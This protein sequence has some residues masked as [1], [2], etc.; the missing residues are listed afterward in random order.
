MHKGC[1]WAMNVG[2]MA[3]SLQQV[4]LLLVCSLSPM[5][6]GSFSTSMATRHS[7]LAPPP[8]VSSGCALRLRGGKIQESDGLVGD[9]IPNVTE[10]VTEDY[11]AWSF[12]V[13]INTSYFEGEKDWSKPSF[14]DL[15]IEYFEDKYNVKQEDI[16]EYFKNRSLEVINKARKSDDE[17]PIELDPPTF[18]TCHFKN[19]TYRFCTT[20]MDR[21]SIGAEQGLFL[22]VQAKNKSIEIFAIKTAAHGFSNPQASETTAEKD[23]VHQYVLQEPSYPMNITVY[24]CEGTSRGKEM[25]PKHWRVIGR[26]CNVTVGGDLC[27]KPA[28]GEQMPRINGLED[29]DG[30]MLEDWIPDDPKVPT[31]KGDWYSDRKKDPLYAALPLDETLLLAPG[32]RRGFLIHTSCEYG[33]ANRWPT[34]SESI[35]NTISDE[36]DHLRLFAMRA[37]PEVEPFTET[38]DEEKFLAVNEN[39]TYEPDHFV[40]RRMGHAFVGEVEYRLK[41]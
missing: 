34:D 7:S 8:A 3:G 9:Q 1:M 12:P 23:F 36:N 2:A 19:G 25:T 32:E 39:V 38:Q 10:E 14:D 31:G 41:D 4:M 28:E 11:I 24:T 35:L 40:R 29:W 20:R 18:K 21:C 33:V 17:P 6:F 15:P 5:S 26:A 16:I 37:M 27:G 30:H 13:D 22:D